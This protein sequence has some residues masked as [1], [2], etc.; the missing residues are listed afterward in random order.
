V[1][2]IVVHCNWIVENVDDMEKART[3]GSMVG[4]PHQIMWGM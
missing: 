4:V 1:R 2:N 3:V